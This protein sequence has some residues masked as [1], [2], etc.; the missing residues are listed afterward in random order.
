MCLKYS[1]VEYEYGMIIT[2]SNGSSQKRLNVLMTNHKHDLP[3]VYGGLCL[4]NNLYVSTDEHEKHAA[5]CDI[6]N[7]VLDG[8]LGVSEAYAKWYPDRTYKPLINITEEDPKLYKDFCKRMKNAYSL[9]EYSNIRK[10]LTPLRKQRSTNTFLNKFLAICKFMTIL[11]HC[12]PILDDSKDI[13]LAFKK[14]RSD[15]RLN[16]VKIN[17]RTV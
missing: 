14:T 6:I 16:N 17:Y 13:H 15:P 5:I 8:N 2:V 11:P 9:E 10:K 3:Y 1:G 12:I 4:D 7:K